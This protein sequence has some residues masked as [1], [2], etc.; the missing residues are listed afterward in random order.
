MLSFSGPLLILGVLAIDL[1]GV[2]TGWFSIPHNMAEIDSGVFQGVIKQV[3]DG[4]PIYSGIS[5]GGFVRCAR[6]NNDLQAFNDW[7]GCFSDALCV[8]RALQIAP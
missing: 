1:H 4:N 8:F 5:Y 7:H 6:K 2:Y 3:G